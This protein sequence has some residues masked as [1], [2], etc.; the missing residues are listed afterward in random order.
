M[1]G[2]GERDIIHQGAGTGE[3]I[4]LSSVCS[5]K[6]NPFALIFSLFSSSLFASMSVPRLVGRVLENINRMHSCLTINPLSSAP[7]PPA[8]DHVRSPPALAAPNPPPFGSEEFLYV[9][10]RG[11]CTCASEMVVC[12][13]YCYPAP[14][15]ETWL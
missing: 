15:L 8:L 1:G 4:D 12:Q 10:L 7:W 6:T 11:V 14:G 3:R 2:W 13:I 5:W 9:H